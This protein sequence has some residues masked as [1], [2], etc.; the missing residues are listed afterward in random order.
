MI[1][2][3]NLS[4]TVLLWSTDSIG[5]QK[6]LVQTLAWHSNPQG[7][8]HDPITTTTMYTYTKRKP[9]MHVGS[10]ACGIPSVRTRDN[11]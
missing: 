2:L 4:N 8:L 9:H 10:Q 5:V 1:K 6:V 7:N 3:C 11:M